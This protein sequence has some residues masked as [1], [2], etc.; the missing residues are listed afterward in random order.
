MAKKNN[1]KITKTSIIGV[2]IGAIVSIAGIV[3]TIVTGCK[4]KKRKDANKYKPI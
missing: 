4:K 3:I 1:N 2:I